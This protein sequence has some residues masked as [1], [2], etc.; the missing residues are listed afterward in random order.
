[1][2]SHDFLRPLTDEA[3]VARE[4]G[5]KVPS[6]DP[7]GRRLESFRSIRSHQD[8]AVQVAFESKGLKSGCHIPGSGVETRRFHAQGK[9]DSIC[10]VQP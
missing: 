5:V 9:M 4:H 3:P 10:A 2:F 7:L 6:E 1:M 8:V